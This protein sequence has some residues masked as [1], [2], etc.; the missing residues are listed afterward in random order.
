MNSY[1]LWIVPKKSA[2][3]T[4]IRGLKKISFSSKTKMRQKTLVKFIEDARR[5]LPSLEE[6][7]RTF[8]L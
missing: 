4:I 6:I 8:L 1:E 7:K 5:P 2:N 3:P